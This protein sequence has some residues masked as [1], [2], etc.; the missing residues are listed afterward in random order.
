MVFFCCCKHF[1]CLCFC[2]CKRFLTEYMFAAF[3]CF[4]RPLIMH[5]IRKR[6]VNCFNLRIC[7]QLLVTP[8]CFLKSIFFFELLC[9]FHTSSGNCIHL[10]VLCLQHSRKSTSLTDK[11]SSHNAPFD[12]FH[13]FCLSF[14]LLLYN[15]YN[16][17]FLLLVKSFYFFISQKKSQLFSI[18]NFKI[19]MYILYNFHPLL[20]LFHCFLH[21]DLL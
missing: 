5:G 1:F 21:N 3:Q 17:V 15:L 19:F 13:R 7:Q 14:C 18:C 9:F 16:T 6:N 2:W 10:A 11:C 20:R 4:D 12:F 8:I